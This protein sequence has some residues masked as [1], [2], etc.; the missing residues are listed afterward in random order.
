VDKEQNKFTLRRALKYIAVSISAAIYIV[1]AVR[2]FTACDA[3]ITDDVYL[4]A[5]RA[6][7]FEDLDTDLPIYHFQPISWTSD[8]GS[9]QIKEVYWIEPFSNLQLTVRHRD[10]VY[11]R[12]DGLYPFDFKLRVESTDDE[13]AVFEAEVEP[14]V[15]KETRYGY[16]YARLS[17]E[18][19]VCVDG[20]KVY[21]EYETFDEETG[22]SSITT[23]TELKG[24]TI[25]Y[26][27]IFDLAGEKIY[28]FEVA[29]R[30]IDRTRMRR[31]SI[32]VTV[33]E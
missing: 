23:D 27:D 20:E 10:D 8:D 13:S 30:N 9:V 12:P 4:D 25:V 32:D 2:L 24:G 6:E 33:V 19:I 11:T 16:T 28:T 1:F 26:L 22:L 18:D 7:L 17:A 21:Y 5:E 31:G 15:W 29:G 14:R 3:D